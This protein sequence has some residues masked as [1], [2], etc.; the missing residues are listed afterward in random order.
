MPVKPGTSAQTTI[1]PSIHTEKADRTVKQ[2]NPVASVTYD[3]FVGIEVGRDDTP[4][5]DT[6]LGGGGDDVL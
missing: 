5:P 4:P 6:T 3:P 1:D 2:S